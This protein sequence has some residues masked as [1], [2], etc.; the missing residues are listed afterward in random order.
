MTF[1]RAEAYAPATIANLG[2]G[3]DIM[4]MALQ[5]PCDVVQ[6]EIKDTPG[7]DILHIDGDGGLLSRDVSKNTAGVA[8]Q[9]ALRLMGETR[10]VNITVKKGLPLASGLGSSAAS[11]VAAAVAVNAVL[12]SPLSLIELL[13]ACLDGEASVSGYHADNVAPCLLGGIILVAGIHSAQIH[14]LPIP[15]SIHLAL[16]TPGVAVPTIKARAVLPRMVSF[17]DLVAQTSAVARLMD[18]IY[19]EDIE[20]MCV[21]MEDDRVIEPARMHLM[22]LLVEVRQVAKRA[23]AYGLIVS[24]A[25]PTLCAICDSE[26]IARSV[27]AAMKSTYDEAAI[28]SVARH[29]RISQTGSRVI[30][31]S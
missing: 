28:S 8:A 16:I 18:A 11:A 7:V 12:G 21:A 10:G 24:G 4:G 9:S 6:V 23:G 30:L 27:A 13:P 14:R 31:L 2:V 3:F 1:T 26:E 20:A 5:E 15:E 29:T 25:G 19:R 17:D 22:P